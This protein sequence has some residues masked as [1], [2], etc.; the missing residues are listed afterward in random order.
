MKSKS[1]KAVFG[2]VGMLIGLVAGVVALVNAY[3][4]APGVPGPFELMVQVALLAL[5]GAILGGLGY[6]VGFVIDLLRRK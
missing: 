3:M 1:T 2:L 4:Y 5:W 6:G